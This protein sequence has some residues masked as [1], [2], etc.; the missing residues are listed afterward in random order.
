MK[1]VLFFYS[2]EIG[3]KRKILLEWAKIGL[4]MKLKNQD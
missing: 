2:R 1:R 4:L 3:I